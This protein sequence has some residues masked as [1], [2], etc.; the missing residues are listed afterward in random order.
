MRKSL[1][2]SALRNYFSLISFGLILGKPCFEKG[3]MALDFDGSDSVDRNLSFRLF[4]IAL[5]IE[6]LPVQ[7]SDFLSFKTLGSSF[8]FLACKTHEMASAKFEA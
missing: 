6:D 1:G 5:K 8:L 4:V 3:T 7:T 2:C